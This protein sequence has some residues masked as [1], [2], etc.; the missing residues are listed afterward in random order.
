MKKS[1]LL[2]AV[3]L[4]VTISSIYAQDKGY[5]VVGLGTSSPLNDFASK[6][7]NNN[8]AGFAEQGLA[9]D[10]SFGYKLSKYFG[11]AALLREQINAVDPQPITDEISKQLPAYNVSVT[12]TGWNIG[13]YMLG[14]YGSLSI[15]E[16]SSIE[17][18]LICGFLTSK[19]PSI[20]AEVTNATSSFWQKQESTSSKSFAY[21]FGL[22]YRFSPTKHFCM[23]VNFDYLGANPEFSGVV[24]TNSSGD[25]SKDTWNQKM[26]TINYTL[27]IG[28]RFFKS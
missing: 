5:L 26:G 18:K 28:Y 7:T 10:L 4:G 23:S 24:T 8:S 12:T 3:T 6:N 16:K 19:S 14:G 2:L 22:G 9:F 21:L 15:N 1:I 27:S 25:I 17:T 20:K 11:V 13:G